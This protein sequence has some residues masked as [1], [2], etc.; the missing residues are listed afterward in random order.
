MTLGLLAL[1]FAAVAADKP[2]NTAQ[3]LVDRATDQKRIDPEASRATAESALETL[4]REP[5]ADLEIE[6]RLILCDYQIEHDRAAA[7][8]Q[9]EFAIAMLAQTKRQGLRAGILIC[10]GDLAQADG[11][12]TKALGN[13]EQ[14]VAIAT[15]TNEQ[16]WL[17]EALFSRGALLGLQANFANGLADLRRAQMLFEGLQKPQNAQ[18]VR[19]S[20]AGLYM[21]MGDDS[22][23]LH[24]YEDSLK[25]HR[26]NGARREQVVTLHNIGRTNEGLKHWDTARQAFSESLAIARDLHYLR[27]EAYALRGVAAATTE[28][29]DALSALDI[30]QQASELQKQI[31]DA[32]LGAR[33]QFARGRAL[34]K[35]RRLTDSAAALEA[36]RKIFAP[37]NTVV[38][39]SATYDELAD[40]HAAL[41]QWRSAYEFRAQAQEIEQAL[42]RNRFDQRFA[43]LKVEFDTAAK[44][45]ENVALLRE[46]EANQ[47]SLEQQRSVQKLQVAVIGL[48]ALLLIMLASFAWRQRRASHAMRSL[49]MTDELTGVPNRRSALRRLEAIMHNHNSP[50]CAVSIVDIDHF[51]SINDKHGHPQGDFILQR[52]ARKLSSLIAEPAFIGRLG[53]EEFVVVSPGATLETARQAAE[54]YRSEISTLDTRGELGDRTITVSI[55][56][57]VS[58]PADDTPVTLLQRADAALYAAK[59][60]G[61]NCVKTEADL[62][63]P[64]T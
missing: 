41:G 30:L 54:R 50:P 28:L 39:L 10:Q 33:I 63:N 56:V 61:R 24:M 64:S 53:G 47:K 4:K 51:K 55:G 23:A 14:A 21:R 43:T 57:C 16:R 32:M 29:G 15:E 25:Q 13:F 5:N 48:A 8:Q 20:I 11:D 49:A 45:T 62:S 37:A 19:D 35:L 34:H 60:A 6:A 1:S 2:S 7:I 12:N 36:A 18:T 9:L 58:K 17:A 44:E 22:Q 38:E 52:V 59:H 46:N 26:K 40:V 27:G 3:N 31:P 42:F